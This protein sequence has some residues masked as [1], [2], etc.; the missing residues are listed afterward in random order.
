MKNLIFVIV[1][2]V[3]GGALVAAGWHF[4][5]ERRYID[6]LYAQSI[7]DKRIGEGEV[8]A[9]M[10]HE[11]DSGQIDALRHDLQNELMLAVLSVDLI[12]DHG[13]P[14]SQELARSFF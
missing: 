6:E 5:H 3:V 2:I 11:L 9:L 13:D 10:L 12:Y 4:G 1:V 14:R 7:L 8:A